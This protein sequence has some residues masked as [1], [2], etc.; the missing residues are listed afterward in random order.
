M[1]RLFRNYLPQQL[2]AAGKQYLI[3]FLCFFY[4]QAVYGDALNS[5]ELGNL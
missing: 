3:H 1:A 4:G 5:V 2:T